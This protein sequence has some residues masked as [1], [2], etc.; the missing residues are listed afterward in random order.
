M[1]AR[2]PARRPRR[3]LPGQ[4]ADRTA[5]ELFAADPA[6]VV[7]SPS[8]PPKAEAESAKSATA[9]PAAKPA[10]PP[11]PTPTHA[12]VSYGPH[13]RNVLDVW[14]AKSDK[15]APLV[16]FI[17]GGGWISGDKKSAAASTVTS[18]HCCVSEAAAGTVVSGKM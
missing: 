18:I 3:G 12:N 4:A 1:P 6:P 13:E 16:V 15:P 17:H 9:K 7:K 14:L 10:E 8:T 2:V 11:A 5:P